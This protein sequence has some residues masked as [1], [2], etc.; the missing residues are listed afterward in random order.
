MPAQPE[1]DELINN[2]AKTLDLADIAMQST[3]EI[4]DDSVTELANR[5]TTEPLEEQL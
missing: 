2:P 5:P 1:M 4:V 3:A